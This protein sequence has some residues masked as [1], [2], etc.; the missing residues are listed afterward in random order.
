MEFMERL[1]KYIYWKFIVEWTFTFETSKNLFVLYK[2]LKAFLLIIFFYIKDKLYFVLKCG[3]CLET[4][5]HQINV[6]IFIHSITCFMLKS[7]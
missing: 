5:L 2:N 3:F 1:F 7:I 6:K 4:A